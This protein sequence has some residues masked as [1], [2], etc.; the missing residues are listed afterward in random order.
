MRDRNNEPINIIDALK[1]KGKLDS[2]YHA[3]TLSINSDNFPLCFGQ[4]MNRVDCLAAISWEK[5]QKY[6]VYM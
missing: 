3:C 5:T 1:V 2:L 6:T 4:D